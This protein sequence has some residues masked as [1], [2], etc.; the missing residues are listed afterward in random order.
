MTRASRDDLPSRQF[1]SW[2]TAELRNALRALHRTTERTSGRP[3][4]EAR[5][6]YIAEDG[7]ALTDA[8]PPAER[9]PPADTALGREMIREARSGHT[10]AGSQPQP[11]HDGEPA[12]EAEPG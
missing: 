6:G 5:D 12:L 10:T 11:R 9:L 7:P 3:D 1:M 2:T 4:A 8:G